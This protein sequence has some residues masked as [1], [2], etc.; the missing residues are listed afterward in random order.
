MAGEGAGLA[1]WAGWPAGSAAWGAAL[2]ACAEGGP[3]A[4]RLAPC[5]DLIALAC[6]ALRAGVELIFLPPT[7]PA[8]RSAE[9]LQQLGLTHLPLICAEALPASLGLHCRS[10]KDLAQCRQPLAAE[11]LD[12]AW[13]VF[14]SGTSGQSG[15]VRLGAEQLLACARAQAR[16]LPLGPSDI[17]LSCLPLHHVGG[18]MAALRVSAVGGQLR[19]HQRFQAAAV[20]QELA[21]VQGC[22]LVP[23]MAQRL[24]ELPDITAWP[25][26]PLLLLGGAG[27]SPALYAA[28]AARGARVRNCWGATETA[29]FVACQGADSQPGADCGSPLPGVELRLDER[30][31]VQVRAPW[32]QPQRRSQ[33]GLQSLLD[34]AGWW[35]SGDGGTITG[36]QLRILGRAD[37]AIHSGGETIFPEQV[38]ARL[39]AHPLI[40]ACAVLP[41]PDEAWGCRL[42]AVIE[43]CAGGEVEALRAWAA[44]HLPPAERPAQWVVVPELPLL[45]NGKLDRRAVA[46]LLDL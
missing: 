31:Q 16:A 10:L 43:Q 30:G 2:L 4:L 11:P 37:G 20:A 15:A 7:E 18:L 44:E 13:T 39:C 19:L 5:P 8:P 6:G 40:T 42:I 17:W 21:Q 28:L 12:G 25:H 33:R 45:A 26:A 35:T 24:L 22:S 38:E 41:L 14:G 36:T 29:A 23:T 3:V 34:P 27:A 32:L 1:D 9:R 46:R